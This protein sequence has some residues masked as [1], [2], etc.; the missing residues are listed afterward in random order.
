M[1]TTLAPTTFSEA[2]PQTIAVRFVNGM[3]GLESYRNYTLVAVDDGPVSW[4]ECDD[5][6]GIVLPVADAFAIAPDYSFELYNHDARALGIR[7]P[8]DALVLVVL[9]VPRGHG[10]VTANLFA[11]IV[12]NRRTWTARPAPL[13]DVRPPTD[14]RTPRRGGARSWGAPHRNDTDEQGRSRGSR[15]AD[16]HAQA[17]TEHHH[18]WRYRRQRARGR[19]RPRQDRDSGPG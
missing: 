13:G 11:P 8:S 16:P 17:G 6:H 7:S 3:P 1:T 2:V 9:T 5:E 4:L 18:R 15:D 10:A 12:I 14:H 19:W